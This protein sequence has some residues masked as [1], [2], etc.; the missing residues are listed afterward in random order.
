M[1]GGENI[2]ETDKRL[3]QMFGKPKRAGS[4]RGGDPIEVLV[5]CIL[6]QNT[7]DAQSDAAY[8]ALVKKFPTWAQLRDARLSDIARVIK[9]SGLANEK[10][11]YIKGALQFIERERG[12]F[13]LDFLNDL[14]EH[15]A[16][17]WLMQMRGVGPKTASIVLLFAQKRNVFPVDTHVLRVTR[18]LGWI[19]EKTTAEQAHQLLETEIPPKMYYRM[20]INLIRL[21]REI[22]RAQNPRCEMCPLKDLCEYYQ[23][24][25]RVIRL[26]NKGNAN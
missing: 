20:H 1:G 12:A 8:A 21:G 16:R 15:D 18:R 2:L 6:S 11:A 19:S 24:V 23:K 4:A 13:T 7:T 14:S 22:C 3:A 17:K 26:R 10:A 9:T 25:P 5:G